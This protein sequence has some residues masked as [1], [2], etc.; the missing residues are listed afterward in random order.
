MRSVDDEELAEVLAMLYDG[1]GELRE[2]G[3]DVPDRLVAARNRLE[4]MLGNDE[5]GI[6]IGSGVTLDDGT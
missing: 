5:Q 6:P 2:S 4:A 1:E 3:A